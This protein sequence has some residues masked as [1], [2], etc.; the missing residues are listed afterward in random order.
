MIKELCLSAALAGFS[1]LA[2]TATAQPAVGQPARPE[3]KSRSSAPPS[4]TSRRTP[5]AD[6]NGWSKVTWQ[7]TVA[8]ARKLFAADDIAE[9]ESALSEGRYP[10]RFVVNNI[11]IGGIQCSASIETD[12]NVDSIAGVTLE[13]AKDFQQLPQLRAS[14]Y[15]KLKE[16]LIQKY[17]KPKSDDERQEDDDINSQVLWSFPS[18]TIELHRSEGRFDLGYVLLMYRAVDKKALGVL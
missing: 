2:T 4:S 8:Q 3:S 18:T 9:P 15:G 11:D 1:L 12:R 13:P 17:G 5:T 14:V 6:V 16:L 10:V 7:M